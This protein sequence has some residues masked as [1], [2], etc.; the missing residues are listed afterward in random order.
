MCKP[1]SGPDS[2]ARVLSFERVG[3]T[4]PDG[5]GP[6]KQ[7]LNRDR[8][9]VL[10]VVAALLSCTLRAGGSTRY[11]DCGEG[12]GDGL[13]IATPW[14]SLQDAAK[15]LFQPGDS[16]LFRRGS[17]CHGMLEPKGSGT[18]GAP[19]LLGAYG[20][21]AL[22][23][24]VAEPGQ[25]AAFQLMN[26]QY[27]T[28]E[29]L[30][31]SGGDP[32]GVFV[33][34][35]S[36][37]LHGIHIRDIVVHDVMGNPK[38]KEGGLLVIAP[39]S[40]R[41]RFEDV[42]VDGVT[43]YGTSQW[44]GI[45]VG[46][47]NH[48]Y[49]PDTVRNSNVVVRNSIV[50]DVAGDGIVLFQVNAGTIEN[51]AAWITG[52]HNSDSIG[53]PNGI[54]TWMC[55]DCAVRRNEAFLTDSPGVDGGAFDIDYGSENTLVADNY[56]HDTEGYCVGIFGY[57]WLTTN[58]VVHDNTCVNNGLRQKLAAEQGAIYLSTSNDGKLKGVEISGNLI[59][60]NPAD[61]A[62]ALVNH[63]EFIGKGSFRNNVIR[64][65]WPVK[66]PA[67]SALEMSHNSIEAST[68]GGI[69]RRTVG[70]E[71]APDLSAQTRTPGKWTLLA[72]VSAS[73]ED[74]DSRG[75]VA[76]LLSVHRQFPKLDVR[77]VSSEARENLRFDWN[78]G[79]VPVLSDDGAARRALHVNQMPSVVLLN[80]DGRLAWRHEG[81]TLPADL[82]LA[83][84][85]W[86][87]SPDYSQ[88]TH[89]Q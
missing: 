8:K 24:I 42:V 47:V 81:L 78:T 38:T 36:G 69:S 63:A 3:R 23:R 58:S 16:L 67:N 33:S 40:D 54:W 66:L 20:N 2:L 49:L 9:G 41:Q 29:H 59:V 62:E 15:H 37:V 71:P 50:H 27:W 7:F 87:G 43:A 65:R 26:Q 48:G 82:G 32:H 22:P 52:K 83:V 76:L 4:L 89:S 80:P 72:F 64:S 85:D 10:L 12:T 79:D 86:I 5:R 56:G 17:V 84:R 51:S 77:I 55:R 31:F 53:T 73:A 74:H 13:S 68:D 11:V 19:I 25:A 30:E 75:Q 6:V 18:A 1:G 57:G 60:W 88:L 34:G 45:M 44:A 70:G 14:R 35:T 39:G 46:G 61:A 21:G 28:I